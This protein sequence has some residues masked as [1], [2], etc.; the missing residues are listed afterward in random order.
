MRPY[1]ALPVVL[2]VWGR[3]ADVRY[4][5]KGGLKSSHKDWLMLGLAVLLWIILW[6]F[7][8]YLGATLY[9]FCY[10]TVLVGVA[11]I[12][13]VWEFG[14]WRT[15]RRNPIKPGP[16]PNFPEKGIIYTQSE[17]EDFKRRGVL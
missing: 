7:L 10:G 3:I 6:A 12:W 2:A 9:S 8:G 16:K 11:W 14:R 1:D 5:R 17:I 4:V 15:R 13:P